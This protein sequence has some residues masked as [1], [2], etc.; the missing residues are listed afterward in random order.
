MRMIVTRKVLI[1][2]IFIGLTLL[3]IVSYNQLKVELLPN[4]QAPF[5]VV[6]VVANVEVDPGYMEKQAVIPLE[7]A[8]GGLQG[9]E[10]I[11]STAAQR[12]GVIY[13]SYTPDTDLKIAQLKLQ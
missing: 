4:A 6:Q 12:R 2:M 9:I 5:L 1:S 11:S 8:V 13:V 10:E 7:G 3:G